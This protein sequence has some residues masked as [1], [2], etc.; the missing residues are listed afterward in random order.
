MI[1]SCP[2]C[3][4]IIREGNNS[5]IRQK[6]ILIIQK[7]ISNVWWL[8][9]LFREVEPLVSHL[10]PNNKVPLYIQKLQDMALGEIRVPPL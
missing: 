4:F 5:N 7:C 10:F 3:P 9:D 2:V 8:T 1:E 6:N